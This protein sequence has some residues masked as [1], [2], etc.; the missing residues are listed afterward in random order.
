[1]AVDALR[2]AQGIRTDSKRFFT[3]KDFSGSDV[4]SCHQNP[5]SIWDGF[6]QDRRTRV[7]INFMEFFM[8]RSAVEDVILTL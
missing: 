1:M 6:D 8:F 2:L 4:T 7:S 3:E 5:A